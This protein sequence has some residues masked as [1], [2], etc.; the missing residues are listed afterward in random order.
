MEV[1]VFSFEAV[2]V[3]YNKLECFG[4]ENIYSKQ[5]SISFEVKTENNT[6]EGC[7]DD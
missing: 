2:N 3:L 5:I 4:R 7:R 6:I 1:T